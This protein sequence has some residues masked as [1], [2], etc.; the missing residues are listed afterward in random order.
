MPRIAKDD[1]LDKFQ[2]YRASRRSRGM[3]LLRIW[4]SD[5]R[6]PG[7]QAEAERQGRLLRAAPEEQEA[8]AFIESAAD[9]ACDLS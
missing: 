6:A 1:G 3:K 5:P 2:R 4:V 9:W 7:F 8:L